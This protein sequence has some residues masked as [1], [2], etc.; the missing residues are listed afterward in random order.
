M[1]I[2]TVKSL[3]LMP[4]CL[5][6]FASTLVS[7]GNNLVYGLAYQ[8]RTAPIQGTSSQR[9][10]MFWV[11]V[12]DSCEQALPGAYFIYQANGEMIQAGPTPGTK[13]VA[14]SDHSPCPLQRGH[15]VNASSTG[16]L[17]FMLP[18]PASGFMTYTI[19]EAKSPDGYVPCTGGSVCSGGP[20]VIT[21]RLDA[22][23]VLSATVLNVYP[24]RTTVTWPTKGSPY[25]GTTSDPAVLH[26]FGIGTI[27][28]DGDH[29]ADDHLTGSGS[30]VHCDSDGD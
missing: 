5:V 25:Q 8:H 7:C 11:Q 30:W 4:L 24:D 19:K 22:A 12:M 27:S 29:D 21:V 15:C 26:N 10:R 3:M 1:K 13:P 9:T 18:L 20:E 2:L 14:V 17:A 16:C 23:G 28:C 6:L